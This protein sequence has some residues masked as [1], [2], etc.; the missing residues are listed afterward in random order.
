MFRLIMFVFI[1]ISMASVSAE[2]QRESRSTNSVDRGDRS[3]SS[4][5]SAR[6]TSRSKSSEGRQSSSQSSDSSARRARG[7]GRAIGAARGTV[8]RS[9]GVSA[10]SVNSS[11]TDEIVEEDSIDSELEEEVDGEMVQAD[12]LQKKVQVIKKVDDALYNCM[13]SYCT[14]GTGSVL[15]EEENYTDAGL[16]ICSDEYKKKFATSED[17]IRGLENQVRRVMQEMTRVK[18]NPE[19][20]AI[21]DSVKLSP[22]K[23]EENVDDF[24][25]EMDLNSLLDEIDDMSDSMS[26]QNRRKKLTGNL[27][28]EKAA[29]ACLKSLPEVENG[30]DRIDLIHVKVD[31]A[32]SLLEKKY[33]DKRNKLQVA[34]D[35]A[36]VKL[37]KAAVDTYAD[38]KDGDACIAE[39]DKKGQKIF[40][41]DY[42][43]LGQCDDLTEDCAEKNFAQLENSKASFNVATICKNPDAMWG[44]YLSQVR[45]KLGQQEKAEIFKSKEDAVEKMAEV[46]QVCLDEM[47][48]CLTSL[49][50]EDSGYISFLSDDP[51]ANSKK[52][53]SSLSLFKD[54][55]EGKVKSIFE[56]MAEEYGVQIAHL[57]IEEAQKIC[58]PYVEGCS[59]KLNLLSQNPDLAK[60]MLE[61]DLDEETLFMQAY[62]RI[63][64]MADRD[65]TKHEGKL[66]ED[67]LESIE[68]QRDVQLAMIKGEYDVKNKKLQAKNDYE[69]AQVKSEYNFKNEKL[70]AEYDY[71]N[72]EMDTTYDFEE[73]KMRRDAQN[74]E[75]KTKNTMRVDYGKKRLFYKTFCE[76]FGGTFDETTDTITGKSGNG[77]TNGAQI[78][79]EIAIGGAHCTFTARG[80]KNAILK[81]NREF[82]ETVRVTD[83]GSAIVR[84]EKGFFKRNPKK[85][86]RVAEGPNFDYKMQCKVPSLSEALAYAQDDAQSMPQN[87]MCLWGAGEINEARRKMIQIAKIAGVVAVGG[88][89]GVATGGVATG[90]IMAGVLPGLSGT[91]AAGIGMGAIGL[92]ATAGTVGAMQ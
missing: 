74:T 44:I 77:E 29:D 58:A 64:F 6:S 91:A 60:D 47:T 82:T 88:V 35:M 9:A 50:G 32:V 54:T 45:R 69:L 49:S 37:G 21:F 87:G 10:V 39:L 41:V 31:N 38:L 61:S 53:S 25:E 8:S 23:S 80:R 70:K 86:C 83:S 16:A 13:A 22:E 62:G 66:L 26:T 30:A 12:A 51:F 43:T 57:P 40:G 7:T 85:G 42:K 81:K 68:K 34:F 27:L 52:S 17:D 55:D 92:G 65:F 46:Q 78:K 76:Q 84:C 71:K 14:L 79:E 48:T 19:E 1:G 75:M 63:Q 4:K 36:M 89:A 33:A 67:R 5:R 73:E 72:K 90:A 11:G 24:E 56:Q 3:T 2:A 15:S 18:L 20:Q 28:F 59:K